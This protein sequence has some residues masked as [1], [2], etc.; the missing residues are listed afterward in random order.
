MSRTPITNEIYQIANDGTL[1]FL[2]S[3]EVV[4]ILFDNPDVDE[5]CILQLVVNNYNSKSLTL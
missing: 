4:D 5:C 3:P 1:F 2:D